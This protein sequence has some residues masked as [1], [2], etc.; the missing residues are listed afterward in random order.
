MGR[1]RDLWRRIAQLGA[2]GAEMAEKQEKEKE[3]DTHQR[4]SAE[5]RADRTLKFAHQELDKREQELYERNLILATGGKRGT[6][7]RG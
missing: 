1:L 6:R 4:R 2:E 7:K 3:A 5:A